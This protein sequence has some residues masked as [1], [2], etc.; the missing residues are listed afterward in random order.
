[1][2]SA[3]REED[4]IPAAELD[5]FVFAF[6]IE[7]ARPARHG[8][9]VRSGAIEGEPPRRGQ[10]EPPIEAALHPG[11]LENVG[12]YVHGHGEVCPSIPIGFG[13]LDD[14]TGN[15]DVWGASVQITGRISV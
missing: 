10:L 13:P 5:G 9:E 15:L 11:G 1:M 8:V 2:W 12:Q 3:L 7:P 14:R 4:E 6:A